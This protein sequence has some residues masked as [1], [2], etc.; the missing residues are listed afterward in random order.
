M[1][2]PVTG[3][4]SQAFD[5]TQLESIDDGILTGN[6]D[7]LFF[8]PH[9]RHAHRREE[10]GRQRRHHPR[11]R[12]AEGRL[13][14]AGQQEGRRRRDRPA[15][16]RDPRAG[17]HALVRPLGLRRQH[18]RRTPRPA[19]SSWTRTRTS[20]CST[21]RCARPTRPA[22]R[23]RSSRRPRPWRTASTT[24]I[25]A[26][27]GLP[28]ALDAARHSTQPLQNEG[29][30]PCKNATLR[31]ALRW[32]CNTVFGK[33]ERRPRQREDDREA[34]KFGFNEEQF[35]TP[36]RADASIYPEDNRPQNAM[37]GIGQAS[38][39]A[40]PLQMAMVA[41]AIANDG[42]LMQPYMVDQLQAPNL[43]VI[44]QHTPEGDEPAAL[45]GERAEAAG[46]DGDRGQGG[47][48]EPTRRSTASR[49]VARPVPR[50]TA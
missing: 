14:G 23:S 24:D 7:R 47:H 15:D 36:V 13:R 34:E 48:R 9:P 26:Q 16:R 45:G 40:T 29:N 5:A 21:G 32:S 2:A 43:N 6:D 49:S 10:E 12:R 4:A 38:N 27:D 22:P 3:Y 33:I 19:R 18:R 42:K 39:R 35:V 8:R 25:D 50:S 37:A 1:W 20:R 41:S 46:D 11:R 44:E 30:I 28:A 17:Q 31:E